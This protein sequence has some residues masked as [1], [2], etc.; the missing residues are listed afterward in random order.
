MDYGKTACLEGLQKAIVSSMS[1]QNRVLIVDD[2][3][4][5]L[6]LYRTVLDQLPD[7][8]EIRTA[9]S[10]TRALALLE[11][12]D[13]SLMLTDLNM[14]KMD[15]FQLLT[16]AQR[17]FPALRTAV[18]TAITD[19]QY[20]ARAY[21]MGVDLF[22][23]KPKT[24]AELRLFAVCI[25]SLLD[26]TERGGFRGVQHKSLVDLVQMECL[27]QSSSLLKITNGEIVARIWVLNGEVIDAA[28]QDMQGEEAFAHI[29]GWP[30][31]AFEVLAAEPERERTIFA[32]VQGLLLDSAQA[33]DEQAAE[34]DART[35]V[36]SAPSSAMKKASRLKGVEFVVAVD[37]SDEKV[38]EHWGAEQPEE[39]AR[40]LWDSSQRVQALAE[41]LRA[42]RVLGLEG[43]GPQRHLAI[44][45]RGG[46]EICIGAQRDF[47]DDQ[48][49]DLMQKV[50]SKWRP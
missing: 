46:R 8:P 44:R 18:I 13:F 35:V 15:G 24:K 14:P 11:S 2:E 29:M 49:R 27:T 20:R 17:K 23:E 22:I 5:L 43:R 28:V 30:A 50:A 26:R 3:Q 39:M 32:A 12:E 40:W 45:S 10:A 16:M 1:T 41:R 4:D 48:V 36:A 7:K 37:G 6:D 25:E 33:L 21:A 38:F 34:G 9:N 47:S 31:G 19:E 42:G